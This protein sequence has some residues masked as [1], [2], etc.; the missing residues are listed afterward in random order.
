MMNEHEIEQ[1]L[2]QVRHKLELLRNERRNKIANPSQPGMPA[3]TVK[4]SPEFIALSNEEVTL[5]RMLE[6]SGQEPS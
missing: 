6:V 1:R 3:H 5:L 2:T 4:D